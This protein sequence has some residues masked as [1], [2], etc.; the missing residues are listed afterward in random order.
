[1][2]NRV[3]AQY[4][5]HPLQ[6]IILLGSFA[7]VGYI[8]SVM[9]AKQLWNSKVWWQSILVWFLGAILLHDL[10]IFPFYAIANR[11]LMAGWQAVTGRLPDRKPRLSPV[12]YLRVPA[13]AS[14]LLFAMFFPG[15]IRQGAHAYQR[16]TG[17]TQAPFL[18]RWLLITAALFAVSAVAYAIRSAWMGRRERR[19]HGPS[20]ET[21]AGSEVL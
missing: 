9:G 19:S 8:V 17:L 5:A 4:G 15:I 20:S 3:K 13:L 1:M 2:V 18:D 6:L 10:V 12:N 16:A 11:S 14:G 7:F 21:A